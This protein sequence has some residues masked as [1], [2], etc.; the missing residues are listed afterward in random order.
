LGKKIMAEKLLRAITAWTLWGASAALSLGLFVNLAGGTLA[1]LVI[2]SCLALSFEGAKILLWQ[3]G[4]L[5]RV[6]AGGFLALSLLA[7]LGASLKI[8]EDARGWNQAA[9]LE[10][11]RK[12]G[13]YQREAQALADIDSQVAILSTKLAELP[14]DWV[15]SAARLS[16]EIRDLRTQREAQARHLDRLETEATFNA[17]LNAA[18]MFDRLAGLFGIKIEQF[19]LG[20]LLAVSAL[21]E[22]GAISLATQAKRPRGLA[23]ALQAQPI[24]ES[25]PAPKQAAPVVGDTYEYAQAKPTGEQKTSRGGNRLSLD[26][27]LGEFARGAHGKQLSARDKVAQALGQTSHQGKLALKELQARGIVRINGRH[28]ELAVPLEEARRRLMFRLEAGRA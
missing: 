15:T 26:V 16:S 3:R 11:T 10:A 1:G 5:W 22:V 24:G 27:W 28:T 21:I 18:S 25:K 12:D 7:S 19:L 14:A 4:G 23:Q 9:T 13:R 20:L 2:A 6:V 17:Q 8:I